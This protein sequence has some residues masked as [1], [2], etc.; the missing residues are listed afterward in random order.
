MRKSNKSVSYQ[1]QLPQPDAGFQ[2]CSWPR[3]DARHWCSR[4]EHWQPNYWTWRS[5]WT[6]R[7]WTRPAS[8][9]RWRSKRNA[10]CDNCR[11]PRSRGGR[12]WRTAPTNRPH[13][14][15]QVVLKAL[16]TPPDAAPKERSLDLSGRWLLFVRPFWQSACSLVWSLRPL[17]SACWPTWSWR[18]W[19]D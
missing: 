2:L 14:T 18:Y 10:K 1:S 13:N 7:W 19:H 12:I 15:F 3:H 5:P 11:R 17:R 9:W 16:W 6:S 8:P 4:L